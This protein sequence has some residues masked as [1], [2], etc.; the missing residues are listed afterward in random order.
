MR[1][2]K[3]INHLGRK[4]S[5]RKALMANMASSLIKHKRI[6]TTV[7][8]AKALKTYVEPLITKCKE[9]S[10]HSRRVVF[11][12]LS[13][14]RLRDFRQVVQAVADGVG[15][16]HRTTRH[17]HHIVGEEELV[18]KFEGIS[19]VLA[20][21]IVVLQVARS[22]KI[23]FHAREF[24]RRGGCRSDGDGPEDLAAVAVEDG[25]AVML[26]H[27]QRQLRL[28]DTRRAEKQKEGFRTWCHH[29]N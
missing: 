18:E 5:H 3:A 1:H 28:A 8:K 16:Q 14:N 2:N 6:Q 24:L 25:R 9:D 20:G 11:S 7:A 4:S 12:Y 19:F 27:P 21:V 22:N 23:M 26:R 29:R 10:T 15:V 13:T 17:N